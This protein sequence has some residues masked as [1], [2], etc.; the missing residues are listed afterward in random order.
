MLSDYG[1]LHI[2]GEVCD[3]K[4]AIEQVAICEPDIILMD[5]SMPNMNGVEAAR[6]IKKSWRDKL[7]I[8]LCTVPDTYITD[9]FLE[10][11]ALAVI[12]KDKI[13]HLHSTIQQ[14]LPNRA[15]TDSLIVQQ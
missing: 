4:Q 7:I 1:D 10:A 3:G 6:Q 15:L 12:V 11:G 9:G 5:Y 14:V 8:G 2:V 13:E